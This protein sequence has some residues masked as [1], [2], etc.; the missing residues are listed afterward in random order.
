MLLVVL[1]LN[2]SIAVGAKETT[3][4][5]PEKVI[6]AIRAYPHPPVIDGILNDEIW[7]KAPTSGGFLQKEPKEGNDPT[8]D[9][10]IQVAYDDDAIYFGITCYD[11]QPDK[12]TS[13]LTRRDEFVE[14]DWVTVYIDSQHDHQTGNEFGVYVSGVLTDGYL[15]NDGQEDG[16]AYGKQRRQ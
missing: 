11:K 9:T 10:K 1:A 16:M 8:E 6:T 13:H 15:F 12:I 2:F 4:A 3:K 5:H 7:Q 14:A